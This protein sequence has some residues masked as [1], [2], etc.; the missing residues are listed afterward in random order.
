VLGHLT[1]E[2]H[3]L[4]PQTKKDFIRR[5]IEEVTIR[6]ISP[7]LFTLHIGWISP[8]ACERDDVAFLWRSTPSKSEEVNTWTPA[9]DEALRQLYPSSPQLTIMEALPYKTPG[10]I[11]NR[12][13]P[14]GVTRKYMREDGR[15]SWTVMY[16]DLAAAASFAKT[17]E[18]K[19]L[20]WEQ[21]NDMSL[22]AKKGKETNSVSLWFF[23]V[24]VVS[25]IH[26]CNVNNVEIEGLS[27]Q[28]RQAT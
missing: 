6:A 7:H 22:L 25:F 1:T 14:L 27:G 11:K 13:Y 26:S 5:L 9:E 12:A 23:P 21:V 10:M 24:D 3:K 8:L 15:F 4:P 28:A 19:Q 18:Q 17:E 20:L 2:F 16:A